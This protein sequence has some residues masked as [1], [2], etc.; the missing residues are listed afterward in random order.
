MLIPVKKELKNEKKK[1]QVKRNNKRWPYEHLNLKL[2]KFCRTR[3]IIIRC[4]KYDRNTRTPSNY[5]YNIDIDEHMDR[6]LEF[7]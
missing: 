4:D 1:K 7:E 2:C 3:H 6:D 5:T